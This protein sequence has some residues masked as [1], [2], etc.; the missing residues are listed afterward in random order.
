MISDINDIERFNTIGNLVNNNFANLF[1]LNKINSSSYDYLFGYYENN[2]LVGFIHVNKL[3]ENID[4]I[5]IV[6]D[7]L[8]RR[9]GIA[10]KLI[11]YVLDYFKDIKAI[12]LEVNENNKEAIGLYN[13]CN[14]KVINKR[15]KYYGNDDAL[16]MKRDV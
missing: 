15:I 11:N 1:D 16:I 12:M 9:R 3:Y 4:I 14:F 2:Y 10:K 8:Y 13:S 5:N 6:V 7:P